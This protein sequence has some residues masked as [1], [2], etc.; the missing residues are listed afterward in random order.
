[1]RLLAAG[2]ILAASIASAAAASVRADGSVLYV[3]EAPVL[4]FS[5]SA[6]SLSPEA[7]CVKAAAQ[8]ESLA[9]GAHFGVRKSAE[10]FEVVASGQTVVVVTQSE[11]KRQ[12]AGARALAFQWSRNLENAFR[13]PLL[14]VDPSDLRLA[15]DSAQTVTVVGSRA[16]AVSISV[17][18]PDVVKATRQPGAVVVRAVAAGRAKVR[19][20]SGSISRTIEVSV[21]PSAASFPQTIAAYV[22]GAPATVP[23][24]RGAVQS[25]IRM[26]LATCDHAKWNFRVKK[27]HSIAAGSAS[28]FQ[29][30]VWASA[31]DAF[32]S[33]GLVNVVVRNIALPRQAEETLWYSNDPESVQ[34]PG[35][36]FSGELARGTSARLLYHHVNVATSPLYF[37]IQ[38]INDSDSAAKLMV[39][40]GDSRPDRNPVRA[41]LTAADQ[42]VRNW[43]IG[44]GEIVIIP[45]RTTMPISL[46]KLNPTE[47]L[48]GLCTLRLVEGPDTIQVRSDAWPPFPI[49][50]RWKAAMQSSTP[51]R[52]VGTHPINEYDR[53][54]FETSAHIY[55]NP[56]KDEQVNYSVGG[57]YGFVRIG[58]RPIT[59]QDQQA[60]LDGNF[61]VIYNIKAVVQNPTQEPT[62]VEV[63]FEA[64]AGYSGG[65]FVLNG[66]MVETPLLA[67]KAESRLTKFHLTPGS[68]T[69]LDIMTLPL[70]GGSYPA[71][72]TIRPVQA[73]YS[74]S[75]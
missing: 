44:S 35:N 68:S 66:R 27:A 40:P 24:V 47:T 5:T 73:A 25:A 38:A 51:W 22:T 36:L 41:G 72:L 74:G 10:G 6:G 57:R 18:A 63:V 71:T 52:E 69:T 9:D 31:P 8:L 30:R 33:S 64:S 26:R 28:T 61:G 4:R 34:G 15:V 46:R 21:R 50:D 55:P 42:Y 16:A 29:V 43:I 20:D 11:A 62:D 49:D 1:M 3:N 65:L 67:P 12:G 45:P 53:A 37:R 39:I 70:S 14:K 23:T 48:S 56:F 54:P 7:R 58:G 32:D 17:D 2:L 19:L 75:Q 13:L 59:R 60:A